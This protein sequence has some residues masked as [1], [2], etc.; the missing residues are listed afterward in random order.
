MTILAFPEYDIL[1]LIRGVAA[2]VAASAKLAAL[3]VKRGSYTG[4]AGLNHD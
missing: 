3:H 1:E 2:L 4:M